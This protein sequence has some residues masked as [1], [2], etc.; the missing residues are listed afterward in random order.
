MNQ[1]EVGLASLA[2][3]AALVGFLLSPKRTSPVTGKGLGAYAFVLLVVLAVASGL[4][5]LGKGQEVLGNQMLLATWLIVLPVMALLFLDR[6]REPALSVHA[7]VAGLVLLFGGQMIEARPLAMVA[8]GAV[9]ALV[10][11][12]IQSLRPLGVFL[13]G[14]G[15]LAAIGELRSPEGSLW[16]LGPAVLTCLAVSLVVRE[17]LANRVSAIWSWLAA[18]ASLALLAWIAFDR[19]GGGL[20]LFGVFSAGVAA[21]PVLTLL[22][23]ESSGRDNALVLLL[24]VAALIGAAGWAFSLERGFGMAALLLGGTASALV[25]RERLTIAAWGPVAALVVYRI[26]VE[27]QAGGSVGVGLEAHYASIGFLLGLLLPAL[28]HRLPGGLS[29]RSGLAS[30]FVLLVTASIVLFLGQVG[31]VALLLA[32]GVGA[33][34]GALADP[35]GEDDSASRAYLLGG[36]VG[37]VAMVGTAI[38]PAT[39][40]RTTRISLLVGTVLF[41]AIALFVIYYKGRL[42]S[43]ETKE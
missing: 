6:V 40:A 32:S 28:Y 14:G 25:V 34:L 37:A 8:F 21:T 26:F 35:S 39:V 17:S 7:G 22:T 36:L 19:F 12:G 41:G 24:S 42:I 9:S 31:T 29:W 27:T 10:A 16:L 3:I 2:G 23:R 13:L 5:T 30:L 11:Y 15:L 20:V 1:L 18:I 38:A 33:V 43:E 4:T